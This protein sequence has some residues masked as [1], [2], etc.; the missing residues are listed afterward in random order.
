MTENLSFLLQQIFFPFPES[1]ATQPEDSTGLKFTV[2]FPENIAYYHPKAPKNKVQ[3]T[4]LYDNTWVTITSSVFHTITHPL[5]AGETREFILD[6]RL[7]LQRAELSRKTLRITSNNKIIVL[8]ISL[9]NSSVQT[10]LVIPADK[11]GR[12]YFIPPVP[13]IKGTTDPAIKVTTT[14]IERSPFKLIIVNAEKQNSVTVEGEVPSTVSLEPHQL[15]R[16]WVKEDKALRAVKADHPVAV[17]FG[18]TCA[19]RH[20]CTCGLLYTMLPPAKE[21]ELKF[22]I[23]PV[24][25]KD[26]EAETFVLLSQEGNTDVKLFDPD[27]PEVKTAGTAVLYRP[28]LLLTL[29]PETDFAACSIVNSIPDTDTFAVIVV[30][31]DFTDG[32]HVGKLSLQSPEWQELKGTDHVSTRVVLATGKNVIWHAYSKMAVYFVGKKG[33]ALFGNP[34]AIISKTPGRELHREHEPLSV[35]SLTSTFTLRFTESGET[36]SVLTF[37]LLIFWFK[38][39]SQSFLALNLAP[40]RYCY[41]YQAFHS[42]LAH[43]QS[44]M[45]TVADSFL[46]IRN[47][48]RFL[49]DESSFS[50]LSSDFA[51]V[52]MLADKAN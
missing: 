7:E 31:K 27:S 12:E 3:I 35:Y 47:N 13:K 49:S 50:C 39:I 2:A 25:A 20:N 4:A 51:S 23:P 44:T 17:L 21:E 9:K 30:H 6:A 32:V 26:A 46:K 14:V 29:I 38:S 36:L 8:A 11:L 5:A 34:A 37:E 1:T 42:R 48:F 18:H 28:G 43:M 40:R 41:P 22:Y 45:I 19:I 10:A 16:I 15:A 52:T 33:S 24:L